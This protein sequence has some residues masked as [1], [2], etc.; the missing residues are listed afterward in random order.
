MDRRTTG[1][2]ITV[3]AVLLCGCPGLLSLFAGGLF[4]I[5]SRIP[6]AQ[7]DILGSND[8]SAALNVGLVG[9]CLGLIGLII[10]I[11]LAIVLLRRKPEE[12][13]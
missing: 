5:I 10:P 7:I 1:I 11:V 8:P 2:V 13:V 9:I 4:A 12:T 3:V 6:G